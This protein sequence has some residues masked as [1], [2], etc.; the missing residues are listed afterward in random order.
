[1]EYAVK[2]QDRELFT[3]RAEPVVIDNDPNM[4]PRRRPEHLVEQHKARDALA[5]IDELFE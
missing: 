1:M 2:T 4:H 3:T 5:R